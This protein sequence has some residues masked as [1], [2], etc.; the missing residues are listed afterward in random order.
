MSLAARRNAAYALL[1]L[2]VA[3]VLFSVRIGNY[4]LWPPD[5]PRYGQVAR[6]MLQRGDWL[7]PHVNGV[8]YTEK[9]PAFFWAIAAFSA[10]F[11]DVNEWSAR[12][13]SVLAALVTM[14]LTYAAAN[15]MFGP[16]PALWSTIVLATTSRFWYQ[17]RT[18]QI[19]MVLTACTTMAFFALWRYHQIR[20]TG[21]AGDRRSWTWL[22][23]FYGA[24]VLGLYAK[25]FPALIF[26]VLAA[27]VF[28]R[29]DRPAL[30]GLHLVAGSIL[31]LAALG[32]WYFFFH[33]SVSTADSTDTSALTNLFR[34]TVG[35][36]LLGVSKAQPPWYYLTT[37]PV[38][39]FPWTFF[40][41]WTVWWTWNNRRRDSGMRFLLAWTL[42]ALVLFSIMI[43]KRA[44][45]LLPLFPA[46][47][48]LISVSV[49]ELMQTDRAAWRKRTAVAWAVL[50]AFV[51]AAAAVGGVLAIRGNDLVPEPYRIVATPGY[52]LLA[53]GF[54]A[55]GCATFI[56]T[57][58]R[59]ETR[60]VHVV[61]A[62]QAACLYLLT[63]L[64]ALPIVDQFKS[65]KT[66]CEPLRLLA[67]YGAEYELYSAAFSREEYIF[68]AEHFHRPVLV[69]LLPLELDV[70]L[71]E[72]VALQRGTLRQLVKRVSTVPVEDW[73][74]VSKDEQHALS[75][76][77]HD[78]IR[79]SAQEWAKENDIAEAR[80]EGAVTKAHEQAINRFR[81]RVMGSGPAFVIVIEDDWR[82][83]LGLEKAFLELSL[84]HAMPVGSRDMVLIANDEAMDLLEAIPD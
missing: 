6:E 10:P 48:I 76:A 43:G 25:G 77:A 38:D 34:Q 22:L 61:V 55:A 27:Y 50:L 81:D 16:V 53:A 59:K 24:I 41:P 67:E 45:Y 1:V 23:L 58:W 20:E 62:V 80:V 68:Y 73:G 39:L 47:S 42:P 32:I 31:S 71:K 65:A 82:W 19:D 56:G 74:S 51:G 66:Y 69:D 8:P 83:M 84:V 26:P 14:A 5:E 60:H 46:F 33:Y 7:R 79:D 11:G 49:V 36:A 18:A 64:I 28:F 4:A 17:A 52:F 13:P 54:F 57:L 9:P 35:R 3:A 44:I 21:S 2:V 75:L 63:A 70:D 72:N 15:R 40:L 12:L 30:R 78:A 37:L 29:K